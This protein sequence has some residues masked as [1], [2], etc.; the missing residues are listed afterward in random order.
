MQILLD[1]IVPV[2]GIVLI[3]YVAARTGVFGSSAVEGLGKF[4]FN[5]AIP[6][7]LFRTMATQALP[8]PIEWDFLLA[9]FG[10]AYLVWVLAMVVSRTGFRR[11][12]AAAS[13]AGM[14]AAFGN[15]VLLGIPL[16][17]TIYGE[18]GTLP[19]FLKARPYQ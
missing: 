13:I 8:D 7:M 9:Y 17:L 16:I 19:V 6:A 12:F 2:F 3:G 10:G 4:V 18:A 14:S 1:I 15:T 11:D 5:F